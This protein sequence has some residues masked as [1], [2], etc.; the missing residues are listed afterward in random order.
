M[1]TA[2]SAEETCRLGA[3]VRWQARRQ[4]TGGTGSDGLLRFEVEHPGTPPWLG[5]R[6]RRCRG[7]LGIDPTTSALT[8][9]VLS[10]HQSGELGF[11]VAVRKRE[12]YSRL[13]SCLGRRPTGALNAHRRLST[14]T[15]RVGV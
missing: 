11:G 8:R 13:A 9:P 15:S 5:R 12:R 6:R 3:A 1:E 10:A 14:K 4:R 7:S 2:P